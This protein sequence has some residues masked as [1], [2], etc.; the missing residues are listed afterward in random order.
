VLG[1]VAG[2][3]NVLTRVH[4]ECFTGEVL[5]SL[6]CDC[7]SQ[8]EMAL[9][10][11]A[12]SGSGA[13]I[14]LRQEGRGI[15][16]LDKLRAYNL[17]DLGHDTVDANLLLGRAA[18]ERTY[19]AAALI[20]RALQIKSIALLTNNPSKIDALRDLGVNVRSRASLLAASHPQN[21]HYLETKA[22]RMGHYIDLGLATMQCETKEEYETGRDGA[23]P[24][25][26]DAVDELT[27]RSRSF[28]EI[29]GRPFVTLSYAQSLDGCLS[30][31]RGETLALSGQEALVFT[32]RLRAAHDAILV[33]IGT[34]FSDD[35][36]LTVRKVAGRN[37]QAV[38]LDSH[39]RIPLDCKL[40]RGGAG[41]LKVA[42][43]ETIDARRREQ[44][45]SSGIEVIPTPSTP[46]GMVDIA[47]V[48]RRL[49]EL[50]IGSVMVEGGVRVI[51]S[52]LDA[53]LVDF[54]VVT[55]VPRFIGGEPGVRLQSQ[56]LAGPRV[57]QFSHFRL[58]NDLALYG[59]PVWTTSMPVEQR[60][61]RSGRS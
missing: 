60:S 61:A 38:V 36:Q 2:K 47:K 4:S 40:V 58:G 14:Y 37:P 26:Q 20:L 29:H 30:A 46:G 27:R 50:G 45:E 6:R 21:N 54:M 8:L 51:R 57:D 9:D 49:A 19:H 1:D 10:E 25:T 11:I 43:V 28:R 33:G 24:S 32:H 31:R 12:R 15:G 17:Q 3:D 5:G 13:L 53:R 56:L 16:L 55:V 41:R 7:A 22:R 48:L 59:A 44:L 42:A 39:L 23:Q 34:V 18:D 52:F 35:P